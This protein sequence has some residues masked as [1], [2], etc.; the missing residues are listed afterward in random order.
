MRG[1]RERS[2]AARRLP[3]LKKKNKKTLFN[4]IFM[5][6]VLLRKKKKSCA[7]AAGLWGKHSVCVCGGGR[8]ER[9]ARSAGGGLPFRRALGCTAMS[10]SRQ[11]QR[12]GPRDKPRNL[13]YTFPISVPPTSGG[14]RW[15]VRGVVQ[16]PHGCTDSP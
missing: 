9:S 10:G 14:G 4:F 1:G 13:L 11:P 12:I 8:T 15:G 6:I 16:E 5:I 7:L 3:K 2:S